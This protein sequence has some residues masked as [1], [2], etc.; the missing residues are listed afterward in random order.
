MNSMEVLR[1]RQLL[2]L[3]A[4]I[5]MTK[6]RIK[7]WHEHYWG[8]VY[9]AFSGGKDS[10]VLRHIVNSMYDNI[11]SV[12]SNTGLE[13]PEIVDF[14]KTLDGVTV[15]RPKR[16][17]RE[18]VLTEGYP[19]IS[20]LKARM[21]RE[22]QNPKDSNAQTRKLYEFGIRK[23]GTESPNMKLSK[24]WL[25]L[26][27]ADFKVSEKCCDYL[28]KEPLE[29]YTRESGRKPMTAMMADEG[30]ARSLQHTCNLYDAKKPISSPMLFWTTED[31]WA[32]IRKFNV[33]YSKIYD[34]GEKRTGCMFC[35]FGVHLEGNENNRFQRMEKTHPKQHNYCIEK[36][37]MGK[38][39]DTIGVKYEAN[40][41]NQ[42]EMFKEEQGAE[43]E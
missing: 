8:D 38:V 6:R 21:I 16:T 34:M 26:K 2:P 14:V 23:D 19:I 30:G 9:V 32:Y 4:K 28:K 3:D 31:V 42:M 43:N 40:G 29:R 25:H 5:E 41:K 17:F 13:Y 37:G 11:P 22:L 10:C 35:M 18:V 27:D 33:P 20:K 24:K 36:L 12:F 39:L 7:E 15:V 1:Q